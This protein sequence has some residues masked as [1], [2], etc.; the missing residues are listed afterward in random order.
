MVELIEQ[1]QT[2]LVPLIVPIT[3]LKHH[4]KHHPMVPQ[5]ERQH[6][7]NPHPGELMLRNLL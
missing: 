6:Y 3:L 5:D 4:F 1:Y 2:G 7:L